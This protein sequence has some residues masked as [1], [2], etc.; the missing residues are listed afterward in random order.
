MTLPEKL[1]Q[2]YAAGYTRADV[3]RFALCG[4]EIIAMW[5]EGQVNASDVK[6]YSLLLR[7]TLTE[8]SA[9]LEQQRA[10]DELIINSFNYTQIARLIGVEPNSVRAWY[11]A[12]K[13]ARGRKRWLLLS[14]ARMT[15]DQLAALASNGKIARG[16]F[17]PEEAGRRVAAMKAAGLWPVEERAR[18]LKSLLESARRTGVTTAELISLLGVGRRAFYEYLSPENAR[19]M[20][21]E[22][23][24]RYENLHASLGSEKKKDNTSAVFLM[25]EERFTQASIVLFEQYHYIG[26]AP[27]DPVKEN[28]LRML[29][30]ATG[31]NERTLRRYLPLRADPQRPVPRA[32]IEAFESVAANVGSLVSAYQ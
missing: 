16:R 24:R 11:K 6:A 1:A 20:P 31:Y 32:V 9:F 17:S 19:L 4:G 12:M 18:R 14:C 2:I 27:R 10:L 25:P 23:V 13:L 5:E 26:F 22:V 30:R 21:V 15:V 7:L 3:A 29:A 28:A 8:F